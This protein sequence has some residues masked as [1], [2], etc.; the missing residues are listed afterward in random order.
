MRFNTFA[1][2]GRF[3]DPSRFSVAKNVKDGLENGGMRYSE[4]APDIIICI[5]G[6]G[7]LLKALY[8]RE[9]EGNYLLIN[10]GTLGYLGDYFASEWEKAVDDIL[11][12]NEPEYEEYVPLVCQDR[13]GHFFFAANDVSLIAPVRA[14]NFEVYIDNEKLASAQ[15]SGLIVSTPLGS[16]AFNHSVD[17]PILLTGNDTYTFSLVAPISNKVTQNFVKHIVLPSNKTLRIKLEQNSKLYKFGGDGIENRYMFGHEFSFYPSKKKKFNIVRY[18][19]R[20]KIKRIND[21]FSNS[22]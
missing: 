9:Y 4:L 11:S 13:N 2:D 20:S 1:L 14:I 22:N 18:R 15:G 17:G 5:G 12:D 16:T 3:G 6:D 19:S 7:S 8:S 21:S 10:G